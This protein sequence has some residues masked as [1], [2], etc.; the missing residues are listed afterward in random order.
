M[1]LGGL[2]CGTVLAID[3]DDPVPPVPPPPVIVPDASDFPEGSTILID[4]AVILPD[5]AVVDGATFDSAAADASDGT[6][7][8]QYVAPACPGIAG[9]LRYVFVTSDL[10]GYAV[11]EPTAAAAHCNALAL[12]SS[13]IKIKARHF[14][15]WTSTTA[16]PVTTR[17]VHGS[18]SYRNV[19][20]TVIATSWADLTDGSLTAS[21][22]HDQNGAAVSAPAAVWTGTSATGGLLA[23]N[24]ADWKDI[25]GTAVRG[26]L[27]A[28][29]SYWTAFTSSDVS[30]GT[31]AHLYCIEK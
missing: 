30:C 31:T 19:L 8:D 14:D 10:V 1:L 3:A 4:G 6:L 22:F 26:S 15:A 13:N 2:A 25:A 28:T 5:G 27:G 9:C 24:C 12:A 16:S 21:L 29:T 17:L 20:E 11:A 18:M 7:P 23:P